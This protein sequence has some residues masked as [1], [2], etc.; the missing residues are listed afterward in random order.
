MNLKETIKAKWLQ[1]VN[2]FGTVTRYNKISDYFKYKEL[3]EL[4]PDYAPDLWSDNDRGTT[5]VMFK[6]RLDILKLVYDSNKA[7]A[8]TPEML[9]VSLIATDFFMQRINEF[10]IFSVQPITGP[11]GMIFN[12]K[13]QSPTRVEI[14]SNAV[15]AESK[16]LPTA[17]L[18][19]LK[20]Q[21][22]N[23]YT[24]GIYD[25]A[26]KYMHYA[27][28]ATIEG[29]IELFKEHGNKATATFKNVDDLLVKITSENS[30]LAKGFRNPANVLILPPILFQKIKAMQN[31][32]ESENKFTIEEKGFLT[33]QGT[34]GNYSIFMSEL[35]KD[36]ECIA[37]YV[38]NNATDSALIIC[39]YTPMNMG[40]VTI[41]AGT[42]E[43]TLSFHC[44]FGSFSDSISDYTTLFTLTEEPQVIQTR[45]DVAATPAVNTPVISDPVTAD[46]PKV[47]VIMPVIKKVSKKVGTPFNSPKEVNKKKNASKSVTR[48][49]TEKPLKT[50][51]KSKK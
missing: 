26:R 43:P 46:I 33:F 30:K 12:L 31:Y 24:D 4:L 3:Y 29:A 10:K 41:D 6:C 39:P 15:L 18:D 28:G 21:T 25:L 2:W 38:G 50:K 37:T 5:D 47:K 17:N 14:L 35:L 44:R 32:K 36:N 34:L 27:L 16:P 40:Q 45:T 20:Q 48:K 11:V 19:Y 23:D 8:P 49:R 42:F 22:V 7:K 1:F 51:P 13:R 9:K